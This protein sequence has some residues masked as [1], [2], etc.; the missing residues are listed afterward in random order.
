MSE[1][2]RQHAMPA[3]EPISDILIRPAL[4][5]QGA[6]LTEVCIRSKAHWGYDPTFMEAAARLL[7]IRESAIRA[8]G[9]LV[10]WRGGSDAPPNGV[11]PCGVAVVVPLRRPGWCELSHLF[12]AP[13]SLSL[14]IGRALFEASVRLAVAQGARNLSILSDPN[15]AAFYTRLGARLCGE[16]PSGVERNRMLPLFEFAISRS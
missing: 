3:S 7:E 1:T 16:A 10:A 4:P 2:A 9:V 5:G 8:G 12:V 15:A 14:G 11:S 13:E 6:V